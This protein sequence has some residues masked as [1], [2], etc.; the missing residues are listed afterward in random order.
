MMSEAATT[1]VIVMDGD[2]GRAEML[3]GQVRAVLPQAVVGTGGDAP[4]GAIVLASVA[5]GAPLPQ[6]PDAGLLVA[7]LSRDAPMPEG[8]AVILRRP[9]AL[10]ELRRAL[11][12]AARRLSLKG[13]AVALAPG[14][15][16]FPARKCLVRAHGAEISLTRGESALLSR[17]ARAGGRDVPKAQLVAEVLHYSPAAD[18]HALETLVWRLRCK[19]EADPHKPEMLMTGTR[20]YRLMISS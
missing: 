15:S 7:I 3:A 16:F 12:E 5:E 20:G 17:L 19:L 11:L 9:L 4:S 2:A 14:L 8:G 1:T 18:T 6:V 10:P 13:E